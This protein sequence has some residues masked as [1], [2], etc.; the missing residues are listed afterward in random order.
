MKDIKIL[1]SGCPKCRKLAELV[2]EAALEL[3][4]DYRIEKITEINDIIGYGVMLTPALV[5]DGSVKVSGSVP[6]KAEIIE[7]LS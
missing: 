1:G 3:G 5:V 7:Y 4:L 2:E 6:S